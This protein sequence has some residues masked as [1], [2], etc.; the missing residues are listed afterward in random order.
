MQSNTG[1]WNYCPEAARALLRLEYDDAAQFKTPDAAIAAARTDKSVPP[2]ATFKAYPNAAAG[3]L[4]VKFSHCK[5]PDICGGYWQHPLDA[6]RPRWIKTNSLDE[7]AD[8]CR[9]FIARNELGSGNWNGG[10][11]RQGKKIVARVS[12]NGRVWTP[13]GVAI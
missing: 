9:A 10:T 1:N 4:E 3:A 2:D 6:G 8:F 5:N 12:Y 13:E 11:V 7:A